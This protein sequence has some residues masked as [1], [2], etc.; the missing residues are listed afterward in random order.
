M[1]KKLQRALRTNLDKLTT[2]QIANYEDSLEVA[3]KM[4]HGFSLTKAAKQVGISSST[5]KKYV[6]P[7]LKFQNHRWIAKQS[8]RLLRKIR[9][10]EKGKQFWITVRG[11]KQA[12]LIGQYHSAIGRLTKDQSVLKPFKKIKIKD[13][14]G[15]VHHLETNITKIFAI[16]EQQEDAE[17]YSIYTRR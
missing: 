10:Y 11:R 15:K 7:A 14:N 1:Q 13:A 4:R 12:T 5:V 17:F 8:D 2:K 9:I 16:L 6:G 3:N